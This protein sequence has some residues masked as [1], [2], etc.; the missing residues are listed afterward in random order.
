VESKNLDVAHYLY[1]VSANLALAC[2]D[3]DGTQGKWILSRMTHDWAKFQAGTNLSKWA[4]VNYEFS[5]SLSR[6]LAETDR[7]HFLPDVAL[8]LNNLGTLHFRLN[9]L[10]ASE[11]AFREAV[12]I[13]RRRPIDSEDYLE[14]LGHSLMNLGIVATA[15]SSPETARKCYEE[16]VRLTAERVRKEPSAVVDLVHRQILL[17]HCLATIGGAER[18]TQEAFEAAEEILPRVAMINPEAARDFGAA[19]RRRSSNP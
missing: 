9:D 10:D 14:N 7:D 16:S 12:E 2:D 17:A 18:D 1:Q 3:R 15:R 13:R 6:E 5:L 4:V 8:C 11:A 19:L